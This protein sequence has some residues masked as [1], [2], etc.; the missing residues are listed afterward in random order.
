MG[1]YRFQEL[2][3]AFESVQ[4]QAQASSLRDGVLTTGSLLFQRGTF[5]ARISS[6]SLERFAEQVH[7]LENTDP[8][9]LKEY[10]A[11]IKMLDERTPDSLDPFFSRLENIL[12]GIEEPESEIAVEQIRSFFIEVRIEMVRFDLT[13]TQQQQQQSDPLVLDLDGDGIELTDVTSGRRFDIN[14]DGRTDTTSFVMGGDAFLALDRNRNGIID[15]GRE[16]FGDQ[17]GATDGFAELRRYDDNSDGT[18]DANDTI[19]EQLR[20]FSGTSL[21]TLA[22]AGIAAISTRMTPGGAAIAGNPVLGSA[23]FTRTDG[24]AGTVAGVL[25]NYSA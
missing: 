13:I 2:S 11:L 23:T 1:S 6:A 22:S 25:L 9:L 3:T 7:D 18:I 24:T 16:L 19:Y 17:N 15:D 12:N 14:A 21:R 8:E 5:E 10:L 20:L 4:I